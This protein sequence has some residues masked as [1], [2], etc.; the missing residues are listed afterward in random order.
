MFSNTASFGGQS[1]GG[2]SFTY[3]RVT[4]K[5][6]V[7]LQKKW[8]G[9][10]RTKRPASIQVQLQRKAGKDGTW[11]NVGEPVTITVNK[12]QDQDSYTW[13]DLLQYTEETDRKNYS[14]RVVELDASGNAICIAIGNR[15]FAIHAALR[16]CISTCIQFNYPIRI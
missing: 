3:E 11:E 1:S 6:Q 7:Q 13:N 5:M 4:P 16:N 2:N 9:D 10:D 14:Y 8:V 15:I 12:N